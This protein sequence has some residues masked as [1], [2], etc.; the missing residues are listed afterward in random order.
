MYV[1]QLEL[2][3]VLVLRRRAEGLKRRGRGLSK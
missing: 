1:D 3:A 2:D